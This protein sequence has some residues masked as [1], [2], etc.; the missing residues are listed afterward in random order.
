MTER[1]ATKHAI[2]RAWEEQEQEDEEKLTKALD[3]GSEVV[4]TAAVV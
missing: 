1:Q 2:A 3:E 4:S